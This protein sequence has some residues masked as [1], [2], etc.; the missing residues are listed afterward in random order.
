MHFTGEQG[1]QVKLKLKIR[2]QA[3][4]FLNLTRS[5]YKKSVARITLLKI[6]GDQLKKKRKILSISALS[7]LTGSQQES[8]KAAELGGCMA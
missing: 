8:E 1:G 6:L 2:I 3:L 5:I 7:Y 4:L